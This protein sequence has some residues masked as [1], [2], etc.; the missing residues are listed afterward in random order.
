MDYRYR[1]LRDTNRESWSVFTSRRKIGLT[2]GARNERRANRK[3]SATATAKN[4]RIIRRY[5]LK[6]L[7]RKQRGK[8]SI[9][10]TWSSRVCVCSLWASKLKIG[11]DTPIV[12]VIQERKWKLESC[13]ITLHAIAIKHSLC[14]PSNHMFSLIVVIDCFWVND[15]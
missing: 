9:K 10:I 5:N 6:S 11:F 4:T 7:V 12:L 14:L 15:H 1:K 3:C 2:G 13:L 8:E